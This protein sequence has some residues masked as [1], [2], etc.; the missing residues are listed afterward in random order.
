MHA[1]VH[2]YHLFL[3]HDGERIRGVL[4]ASVAVGN[5]K[6]YNRLSVADAHKLEQ[7]TA[8]STTA[9]QQ[10]M[11][12][13]LTK[14]YAANK[15]YVSP[16]VFL[17]PVLF[18]VSFSSVY[19][20]RFDIQRFDHRLS[21]LFVLYSV[22]LSHCSG[23]NREED[24]CHMRRRILCILLCCRSA[25]MLKFEGGGVHRCSDLFIF[26][27]TRVLPYFSAPRD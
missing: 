14:S 17:F 22:M 15:F 8:K 27:N 1:F 13:N 12:I 6:V 19:I 26:K 20:Q 2:M 18:F 11:L 5:G 4:H 9:P 3:L 16:T 23:H 21:F 7:A 25:K 10:L 24:T